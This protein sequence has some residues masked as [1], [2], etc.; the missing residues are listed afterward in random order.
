M[1]VS[2]AAVR[3]ITLEQAVRIIDV[4][5]QEARQ[6]QMRPMTL[7]V[8]DG[9]GDLVAYK[10]EDHTGIG[11]YHIAFGKAYGA[12]V[13]NRSSRAIGEIAR[14]GAMFVQSVMTATG[15]QLIP[16]PG[17]VLVKDS[18]GL[19]IGAVGSSGDDPQ[20]DEAIAIIG[21]KAAG[22]TPEPLDPAAPATS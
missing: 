5:L 4:A 19:I 10:R 20:R 16:S 3:G 15:G 12:L 22:L 14:N 7:A 11:R 21:V 2:K 8:L 9:G 13:M 6:R 17:G 1:A 18:A